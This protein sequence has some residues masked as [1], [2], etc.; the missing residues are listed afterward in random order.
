MLSIKY[1]IPLFVL[2][3]ASTEEIFFYLT[4]T[5]ILSTDIQSRH[6]SFL[7]ERMIQ[8]QESV[9]YFIRENNYVK[10]REQ[11]SS[12]GYNTNIL[13]VIL[14]NSEGKV[15]A[16]LHL[17][18]LGHS[19][20]EDLTHI[21]SQISAEFSD[22]ILRTVNDP[23]NTK[24]QILEN[25]LAQKRL[26]GIYP[27]NYGVDDENAYLDRQG[28]LI[29]I[30]DTKHIDIEV[31]AQMQKQLLPSMLFMLASSV[32]LGVILYFYI[33]R[34]INRLEQQ[35]KHYSEGD[36][37]VTFEVSGHDELSQLGDTFNT[38]IHNIEEQKNIILE[39]ERYLSLTLDS[40]GDGV[41]ATDSLGNITRINPT[42]AVMTGFSQDRHRCKRKR[43]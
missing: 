10:I 11:I 33:V 40:I 12:L 5:K 3:L 36:T 2:L 17:G 16:S 6:I 43:R 22:Y 20:K 37:N 38:M 26:L 34:R 31:K 21:N 7:R 25:N 18:H 15:D 35:S 29:M 4:S 28:K 8:T 30:E 42:A 41:I 39:K 19:L 9:E 1:L 32:F 27:I 23:K 13:E 14:L 24:K